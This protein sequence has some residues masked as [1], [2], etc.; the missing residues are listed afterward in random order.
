MRIVST[1]ASAAT[2][3]IT[4]L[5][6]SESIFFTAISISLYWYSG[7]ISHIALAACVSPFLLLRTERSNALGIKF[8]SHLVNEFDRWSDPPIWRRDRPLILRAFYVPRF[9]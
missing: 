7:H 8:T 5:A 3:E 9:F 2:G 6:I 1:R 4:L